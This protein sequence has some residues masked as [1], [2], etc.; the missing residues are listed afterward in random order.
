MVHSDNCNAIRAS[1]VP[2]D[3]GCAARGSMRRASWVLLFLLCV[4][5]GP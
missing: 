4:G 5:A 3:S 1:L 2:L